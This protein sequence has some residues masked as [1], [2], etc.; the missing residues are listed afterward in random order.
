MDDRPRLALAIPTYNRA[1]ILADNL[2]RMQDDLRR[3]RIP[4]YVSDDSPNDE[5]KRALSSIKN[6][7]YR[8]NVPALG[9]DTNLPATLAWPQADYVWLLGD[10]RSI[11]KGQL[12]KILAFLQDQDLLFINSHSDI[13]QMISGVC[14]EAANDFM[15]KVLWHQTMTGTT[16]FHRRVCDWAS[17]QGESLTIKP[18]FP[19][20]SIMLGYATDHKVCVGWFGEPSIHSISKLSYWH[21]RTVSVFVDHWIAVVEAFP[22]IIPPRDQARVIRSHSA[23]MN[24]FRVPVLM[25]ARLSGAFNWQ[26]LRE[27]RFRD[28]MHL[29]LPILVAVLSIPRFLVVQMKRAEEGLRQRGISSKSPLR[30]V[31][32]SMWKMII[33]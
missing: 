11:R 5:T 9:H 30:D 22:A 26:R 12:D 16:I 27:R 7:Y 3:L 10:T 33:R 13:T 32:N 25:D 20:L 21:S 6:L 4:I 23:R 2:A 17:S 8:H 24:L 14:G 19:Q 15:R 31:V 1:A 28:A 29:P 18:D